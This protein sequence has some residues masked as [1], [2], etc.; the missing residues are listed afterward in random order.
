MKYSYHTCCLHSL[1]H[2]ACVGLA[3]EHMALEMLVPCVHDEGER[4]DIPSD[5]HEGQ[6]ADATLHQHL[7]FLFLHRQQRGDSDLKLC[8]IK[9]SF[10]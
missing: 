5:A 6:E 7:L 10:L 9:S 4:V 1:R 2:A 3:P 8:S